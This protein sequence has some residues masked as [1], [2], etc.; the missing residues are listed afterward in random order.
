MDLCVFNDRMNSSHQ[1]V[2]LLGNYALF[3]RKL[4]NF[5]LVK[6]RFFFLVSFL[7]LTRIDH[8]LSDPK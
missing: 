8:T 1:L 5:D 6:L 2:R 3:F 4:G 7:I